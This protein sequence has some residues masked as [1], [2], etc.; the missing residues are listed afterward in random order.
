MDS[1]SRSQHYQGCQLETFS[2]TTCQMVLVG[3]CGK[4]QREAA[5]ARDSTEIGEFDSASTLGVF[6]EAQQLV[7]VWVVGLGD[8]SAVGIKAFVNMIESHSLKAERLDNGIIPG[9]LKLRLVCPSLPHGFLLG[10]CRLA[11][12]ITSSREQPE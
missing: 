10:K 11:Q 2:M 7:L 4:A 5:R 8:I 1:V 6:D 3:F 9:G 12:L